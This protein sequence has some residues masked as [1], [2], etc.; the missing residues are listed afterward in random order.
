ME[1]ILAYYSFTSVE[2]AGKTY[3][4]YNDVDTERFLKEMYE[5]DI[6]WD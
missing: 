3:G 6:L 1:K 2:E 4:F 5:E